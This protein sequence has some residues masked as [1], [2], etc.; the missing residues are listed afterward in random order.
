MPG[1]HVGEISGQ[2]FDPAFFERE[3]F[4]YDTEPPSRAVVTIRHVY[5][6][7][8]LPFLERLSLSF[9]AGNR[10]ITDAAV[11]ADIAAEAGFDRAEFLAAFS[12]DAAREQTR[13]D[14]TRCQTAGIRG[15]PTLLG[16]SAASGYGLLTHGFCGLDVVQQELG[17][18]LGEDGPTE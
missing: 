8:A 1:A 17:Q 6:E 18:W 11:I 10:D 2:P 5:P 3:G 12:S 15:F 7:A 14:F 9:Y 13:Q 4:V 16:G